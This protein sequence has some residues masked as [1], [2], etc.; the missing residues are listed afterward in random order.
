VV[1]ALCSGLPAASQQ[2]S[3][4]PEAP[5]R[6]VLMAAG[7]F[8]LPGSQRRL[9]AVREVML[10]IPIANASAG[11]PHV[12]LESTPLALPRKTA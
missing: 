7:D 9:V 8:L 5:L 4:P 6:V 3:N 11:Q 2:M 10:A 12:P 1:L